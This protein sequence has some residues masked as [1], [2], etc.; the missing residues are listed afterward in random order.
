MSQNG[1]TPTPPPGPPGSP[2]PDPGPDHRNARIAI[3]SLIVTSMLTIIGIVVSVVVADKDDPSDD[4]RG[5]GPTA[6]PFR[7]DTATPS[8]DDTT[9][10]P[11]TTTPS[12]SPTPTP[13]VTTPT[14]DPDDTEGGEDD[15]LTTAQRELRDSLN[16]AQW[17]RESCE[18][19]TA[20]GAKASL[21]CTVTTQDPT[22]GA[23]TTK[24]NISVYGS[25]SEVQ[26]VFR[27]YTAGLPD[28][29]CDQQQNVRSVWSENGSDTPAGDAACY[30]NTTFQYVITCTYYDRPALF[31][32]TG[33]DFSAL[34]RWWHGLDPIFTD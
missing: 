4:G 9:P 32:V 23:L 28:G 11:E 30:M 20:P 18:P 21:R 19:A 8:P 16:P 26:K 34:N 24:A 27:G 5:G 12:P 2:R 3:I 25:K 6:R 1:P 10:E 7:D 29:N 22:Y 31:A 17:R 13:E 15:G 14:A 33:P